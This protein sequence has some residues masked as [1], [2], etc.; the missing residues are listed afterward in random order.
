[1]AAES[2]PLGPSGVATCVE[3]FIS[4]ASDTSQG[5]FMNGIT[6]PMGPTNVSRPLVECCLTSTKTVGL[7]GTGTHDVRLDFHT[8]PEAAPTLKANWHQHRSLKIGTGRHHHPIAWRAASNDK[9]CF[10]WTHQHCQPAQ[11][12]RLSWPSGELSFHPV[13]NTSLSGG[14]EFII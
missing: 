12:T 5:H 6:L 14:T 7:L 13:R 11:A 10:P 4:V 2:H 3:S 1:M 8:V 9:S